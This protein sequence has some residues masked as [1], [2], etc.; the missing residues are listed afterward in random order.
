LITGFSQITEGQVYFDD[1]PIGGLPAHTI[2]EMGIAR[3]FQLVRVFQSMTVMENMMLGYKG[4][5][6]E[7][8][9][10]A[11]RRGQQYVQQDTKALAKAYELLDVVGLRQAANERAENLPYAEQ[12]MAEI[13][14]TLMG[15]PGLLMLDEPASGI[16]PTLVNELLDYIRLLRDRQGK[17]IVVIE[18]DMRVIMNLCDRI[19]ALDHGAKICE[20]SPGEVSKDPSVI[21]AYL[22]RG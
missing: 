2:A 21:E 20:G 1:R 11:I 3:T 9:W 4:H 18:H 22:G 8:P 17:T 14:R 13:A 10:K 5:V 15:D 7:A 12:K 19:V 16:A 6:G